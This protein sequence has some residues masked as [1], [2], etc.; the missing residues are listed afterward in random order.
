M[1]VTDDNKAVV[2]R[3]WEEGYNGRKPS[4][5]DVLFA[6]SYVHHSNDNVLDRS[7]FREAAVAFQRSFPD[8]AV[9]IEQVVA[10]RDL[11]VVRW[12]FYGT[13][14]AD[15]SRWGPATGRRLEF[16]STWVSLVRA[17]TIREDWETWDARGV[18]E[19]LHSE[20]PA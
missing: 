15:G 5:I 11:V 13:H 20:E 4:L 1:G 12:R 10:E 7:A 14:T 19:R 9:R 16:P 18:V 8:S 3:W 6:A 2:L 17:N